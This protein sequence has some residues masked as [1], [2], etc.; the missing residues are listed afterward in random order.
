[1]IHKII[2]IWERFDRRYYQQ[3]H[4]DYGRF[5][6]IEAS[7]DD[8]DNHKHE[9]VLN[10]YNS[11]DGY[12]LHVS[13]NEETDELI[14]LNDSGENITDYAEEKGWSEKDITFIKFGI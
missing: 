5:D 2:K 6:K 8:I 12:W 7:V 14:I 3:Y 1:M 11:Y 4:A 9:V 10:L 13:L